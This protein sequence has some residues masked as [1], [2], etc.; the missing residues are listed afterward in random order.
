MIKQVCDLEESTFHFA[1]RVRLFTH[2]KNQSGV[3]RI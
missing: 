1:K 3:F 2:K